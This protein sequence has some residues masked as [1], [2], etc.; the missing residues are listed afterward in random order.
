MLNLRLQ[1]VAFEKALV[2]A[3]GEQAFGPS[4]DAPRQASDGGKDCQKA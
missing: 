1:K 4:D 2:R 3:C